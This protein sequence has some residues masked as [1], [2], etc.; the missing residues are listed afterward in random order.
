MAD[1]LTFDIRP[2]AQSGECVRVSPLVRRIV[3]NNPGPITFTG[4]CTYIVGSGKVAIIDPG[5][6]V[7]G[8]VEA[9]L[10]AVR[11]ETVTARRSGEIGAS[12]PSKSNAYSS[13]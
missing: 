7:P 12:V 4:T 3:A 6:E 2:P 1:D 10:E 13:S 5:P 8:Q 9:L 11:G